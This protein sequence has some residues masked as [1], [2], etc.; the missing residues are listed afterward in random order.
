[1][2]LNVFRPEKYGPTA[3]SGRGFWWTELPDN[4]PSSNWIEINWDTVENL[5]KEQNGLATKV[6]I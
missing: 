2:A 6:T 3:P 5:L 1:M 4:S